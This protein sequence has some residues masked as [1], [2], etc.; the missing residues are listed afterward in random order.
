MTT[1][2]GHDVAQTCMSTVHIGFDQ[3]DADQRCMGTVMSGCRSS[4]VP[5]NVITVWI[6]NNAFR[7][8][9]HATVDQLRAAVAN[10]LHLAMPDLVLVYGKL[11]RH[12][13]ARLLEL[14]IQDNA[15]VV[16]QGG[17]G[18]G[19][20]PPCITKVA[21]QQAMGAVAVHATT[22][23]VEGM[24]DTLIPRVDI[25]TVGLN[26]NG[27]TCFLNTCLQV[28]G[29]LNAFQLAL[30]C[31]NSLR[32][33][34]S[35]E[36]HM[37]PVPKSFLVYCL[38]NYMVA[39]QLHANVIIQTS[40]DIMQRA[41]RKYWRDT[42][43]ADHGLG[44]TLELMDIIND[45]LFFNCPTFK[46]AV[47]MSLVVTTTKLC[48]ND[49]CALYLH[50]EHKTE[51]TDE[52]HIRLRG[53]HPG[54]T[55]ETAFDQREIARIW[56]QAEWPRCSNC[57]TPA[58]TSSQMQ[59]KCRHDV[60]PSV[61]MF[62][63][64][65]DSSVDHVA[66]HYRM[67]FIGPDLDVR[68]FGVH[69]QAKAYA[70][71]INPLH[72]IGIIRTLNGWKTC[73]DSIIS[74]TTVD[75]WELAK[76]RT[77]C[78]LL[79]SD[80][81][82]DLHAQAKFNL[83]YLE[84]NIQM[85]NETEADKRTRASMMAR[86][87]DEHNMRREAASRRQNRATHMPVHAKV[88]RGPAQVA[89]QAVHA[90]EKVKALES[91]AR[92]AQWQQKNYLYLLT[93]GRRLPCKQVQTFDNTKTLETFQAGI[94]D[95][96]LMSP[97][98]ELLV[99]DME[100]NARHARGRPVL[101]VQ[102]QTPLSSALPS[103]I[104]S[105]PE[106][107]DDAVITWGTNKSSF[108]K[109]KKY[110][111]GDEVFVAMA[112]SELAG[113]SIVHVAVAARVHLLGV[114]TETETSAQRQGQPRG[115]LSHVMKEFMR[116]RLC[117]NHVLTVNILWNGTIPWRDV[118]THAE[119]IYAREI[120]RDVASC[121][122]YNVRFVFYDTTPLTASLCLN[123]KLAY[124][125]NIGIVLALD[126]KPTPQLCA[127]VDAS[128]LRS[129]LDVS[130]RMIAA[131]SQVTVLKIAR[132]YMLNAVVAYFHEP[133]GCIMWCRS[134][135]CDPLPALSGEPPVKK[136][137]IHIQTQASSVVFSIH[138]I[139]ALVQLRTGSCAKS[140]TA[141]S[142][143]CEDLVLREMA[144]N[145]CGA[146]GVL[147]GQHGTV[148]ELQH[149]LGQVSVKASINK[150][151]KTYKK[152]TNN[153]SDNDISVAVL[154]GASDICG[155]GS[156]S[157]HV[158]PGV[159][160][161]HKADAIHPSQLPP[162][163]RLV[164]TPQALGIHITRKTKLRMTDLLRASS[165]L[166]EVVPYTAGSHR[167]KQ[168][169][170]KEKLEGSST[171]APAPSRFISVNADLI[172]NIPKADDLPT[173]QEYLQ[174]MS[175][176]QA[177]MHDIRQGLFAL[178]RVMYKL[179]RWM[180][181]F[182]CINIETEGSKSVIT[183][184]RTLVPALQQPADK[185]TP[186]YT[187]LAC[188]L[189]SDRE[190]DETDKAETTED[191]LASRRDFKKR[192]L[193]DT[194]PASDNPKVLKKV[195]KRST[196]VI[197]SNEP[198]SVMKTHNEQTPRVSSR[199]RRA[200]ARNQERA[201]D[202]ELSDEEKAQNKV[203]AGR[204]AGQKRKQQHEEDYVAF[205]VGA[206]NSDKK[207]RRN[208]RGCSTSA[209]KFV[210]PAGQGTLPQH[211]QKPSRPLP[212]D[213]Y[214]S[215]KKAKPTKFKG[216]H[217][218][219]VLVQSHEDLSRP[220]LH[221]NNQRS[222][223]VNIV[224]VMR[225]TAGATYFNMASHV[226]GGGPSPFSD[227]KH[228]STV[229]R[230][231]QVEAGEVH[232]QFANLLT[233][234]RAFISIQA[235][236]TPFAVVDDLTVVTGLRA[237]CLALREV[238]HDVVR[239]L[240]GNDQEL[241]QTCLRELQTAT[242]AAGQKSKLR[243]VPLAH[244][245]SK[246]RGCKFLPSMLMHLRAPPLPA[247][248]RVNMLVA[249][250]VQT[251]CAP[252]SDL[253]P[254]VLGRPQST[255]EVTARTRQ[256]LV[257]AP[258]CVYDGGG[259]MLQSK[260]TLQLS[261]E[262]AIGTL[263]INNDP[264]CAIKDTRP[265]RTRMM[266]RDPKRK[267]RFIPRLLELVPP[268]E[269]INTETLLGKPLHAPRHQEPTPELEGYTTVRR[270]KPWSAPA[271]TTHV[272]VVARLAR[273]VPFQRR[274]N[275][276]ELLSPYF[277]QAGCDAAGIWFSPLEH[278]RHTQ[279]LRA[280]HSAG[281]PAQ[282]AESTPTGLQRKTRRRCARRRREHQPDQVAG[283]CFAPKFRSTDP[284]HVANIE[285]ERR[286]LYDKLV[287]N[288]L[289]TKTDVREILDRA[290]IMSGPHANNIENQFDVVCDPLVQA[291]E[292]A[293]AT[294]AIMTGAS[295]VLFPL[296]SQ[297]MHDTTV[298]KHVNNQDRTVATGGH[299]ER[300]VHAMIED[301]D[302]SVAALRRM[303]TAMRACS[304]TGTC[305]GELCNAALLPVEWKC[306]IQ[307]FRDTMTRAAPGEPTNREVATM[308]LHLQ[309]GVL[310]NLSVDD[311]R[312]LILAEAVSQFAWQGEMSTNTGDAVNQGHQSHAIKLVPSLTI[313]ATRWSP[314][315]DFEGS[316][317]DVPTAMWQSL[318][319]CSDYILVRG[320]DATE[321]WV[322]R[323]TDKCNQKVSA[324]ALQD[325]LRWMVGQW[326]DQDTKPF[327]E[328]RGES[329]DSEEWR[330]VLNAAVSIQ[331][332]VSCGKGTNAL[333]DFH[334]NA[335]RSQLAQAGQDDATR[336]QLRKRM[337][338]IRNS[339]TQS[340]KKGHKTHKTQ[341]EVLSV[342]PPEAASQDSQ[343]FPILVSCPELVMEPTRLQAR[344]NMAGLFTSRDHT[345]LFNLE[346]TACTDKL[347][348]TVSHRPTSARTM[349]LSLTQDENVLIR[350]IFAHCG[351]SVHVLGLPST[352]GPS[353]MQA[354][355]VPLIAKG[356]SI[357]RMH[358]KDIQNICRKQYDLDSDEQLVPTH[359]NTGTADCEDWAREPTKALS[360]VI[361]GYVWMLLPNR[362]SKGESAASCNCKSNCTGRCSCFKDMRKCDPK[363]C[364]CVVG[365]CQNRIDVGLSEEQQRALTQATTVAKYKLAHSSIATSLNTIQQGDPWDKHATTRV[366]ADLLASAHSTDV[367]DLFDQFTRKLVFPQKWKERTPAAEYAESKKPDDT[368]L[369]R[370][371]LHVGAIMRANGIK[372]STARM[373][374]FSARILCASINSMGGPSLSILSVP[375]LDPP[376]ISGL[377]F[378]RLRAFSPAQVA[379]FRTQFVT[380]AKEHMD[381]AFQES[382]Q[383]E[384]KIE[385]QFNN[386][387]QNH[388]NNLDL[389]RCISRLFVHLGEKTAVTTVALA[390]FK[391]DDTFT[392][393]IWAPTDR[394]AL[395]TAL[396]LDAIKQRERGLCSAHQT[397]DKQGMLISNM[398]GG[399]L[400]S[401]QGQ[402]AGMRCRKVWQYT[403]V[404][405]RAIAEQGSRVQLPIPALDVTL[406]SAQ[407]IQWS[408]DDPSNAS[409]QV[410]HQRAP[411]VAVQFSSQL[412]RAMG[413]GELLHLKS[414]WRV[415]KQ[416]DALRQLGGLQ[417]AGGFMI[418]R[419]TGM[420]GNRKGAG[421]RIQ[422]PIQA[423]TRKSPSMSRVSVFTERS[424]S[425]QSLKPNRSRTRKVTER[426]SCD[427]SQCA[428]NDCSGICAA[429]SAC[430]DC[431]QPT[432]VR[433]LA[434]ALEGACVN[435]IS[436]FREQLRSTE[437]MM[438]VMYSQHR[439]HKHNEAFTFDPATMWPGAGHADL[440]RL[441]AHVTRQRGATK[442]S[443]DFCGGDE[444]RFV[445]VVDLG[446]LTYATITCVNTGE[447]FFVGRGC[448]RTIRNRFTVP[449]E[450]V[451]SAMD[452]CVNQ[453]QGVTQASKNLVYKRTCFVE[454]Q[455][456][457]G[458]C[459]VQL[460][461]RKDAERAFQTA[462]QTNRDRLAKT[463]SNFQKMIR[464]QYRLR[465]EQTKF[466]NNLI[467]VTSKLL[468]S[469]GEGGLILFPTNLL[470]D[471]NARTRGQTH[472]TSRTRGA[473]KMCKF[474]TLL[475]QLRHDCLLTGAFL[476]TTREDMSSKWCSI[477]GVFNGYLGQS[478]TFKCPNGNC[479]LHVSLHIH[480][481]DQ[482]DAIHRIRALTHFC[483]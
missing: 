26:N 319:D 122:V 339:K 56:E 441:K 429:F 435:D 241:Q 74:D 82:N 90:K 412:A 361:A 327:T 66:I 362:V 113:R 349:Q 317:D 84:P 227:E 69:Y 384:D 469:V 25:D 197:T 176:S 244:T 174:A 426:E 301:M 240:Q 359:T 16:L 177:Y 98:Q 475:R 294:R 247:S 18:L 280:D 467:K 44:D 402:D 296:L 392:S 183:W 193:A 179:E 7:C 334:I 212:D 195:K 274:S 376:K 448:G 394:G 51:I 181:S 79:E 178:T 443:Y 331:A 42:F 139:A 190:P 160:N 182:S 452:H 70:V 365:K 387:Q 250:S 75:D 406:V 455:A 130:V 404:Q 85:K 350:G 81:G 78:I 187:Y 48:L 239:T 481:L 252:C 293:S 462:I 275:L 9:V 115:G 12:G 68:K 449:L 169:G 62:T 123:K 100:T 284:G 83:E 272:N 135:A 17:R 286:Q 372:N 357:L 458:N 134:T 262:L 141:G 204:S 256:R 199:I 444:K 219:L 295:N 427:H 166:T 271:P 399:Q 43:A 470:D 326:W 15:T 148:E 255:V 432:T 125:Y 229:L 235:R 121:T 232:Q 99:I 352:T 453:T 172:V 158:W 108:E 203:P 224:P 129:D 143:A 249:E 140:E 151:P 483:R 302:K 80:S 341:A 136:T 358:T 390:L 245:D 55:L 393:F 35:S 318:L 63:T 106:L 37:L 277:G 340:N 478:R 27:N 205:E 311:T 127:N 356:I 267:T 49:S 336:V 436:V 461:E 315:H 19:G 375:L 264:A 86:R 180:Q 52:S 456:V 330:T 124:L 446:V 325:A 471:C 419:G 388:P 466:I 391:H 213:T 28:L 36:V 413:T 473:I 4:Q 447:V 424:R 355:N 451:Q 409:V 437:R 263:Q 414:T 192:C 120:S 209:S 246:S 454:A 368:N 1:R 439:H 156:F 215:S 236:N 159:A 276:F 191:C 2:H 328:S 468:S 314:Q 47:T 434:P 242:R 324:L 231:Q 243:I 222:R 201:D 157:G 41:L 363:I 53:G 132:F 46:L 72:H 300:P 259:D 367:V 3:S 410:S 105:I 420:A 425:D 369:D 378:E 396:Q 345:E 386:W 398:A 254:A 379:A 292:T 198:T 202:I 59:Y 423:N 133:S 89:A 118:L 60:V 150:M 297:C 261:P 374:I 144:A 142:T 137:S 482:T 395:L 380:T 210:Q 353:D 310:R 109:G 163:V 373:D 77:H 445:L 206:P 131:A 479:L 107:Q 337:P 477:C 5:P 371:E 119:K 149:R 370:D 291:Q 266:E 22:D 290:V 408:R 346:N 65:K 313:T 97:E 480:A 422:L 40:I 21:S 234:S 186:G 306:V 316:H 211:V 463:D 117:W 103:P 248:S 57:N 162:T 260:V 230:D 96:G 253:L 474:G 464:E 20:M 298:S 299:E 58:K 220:E 289:T 24:Q 303:N 366:D 338:R 382:K 233:S 8:C 104:K 184:L 168:A 196:R 30:L 13:K 304:T 268:E 194:G 110:Y 269:T 282:T 332:Q 308:R 6:G 405:P 217:G 34:Y 417:L 67:E 351:P 465:D 165:H 200:P 154:P 411:A 93:L 305:A 415:A 270:K 257:L 407:G 73:N 38:T 14:G 307:T 153:L 343:I 87:R 342:A 61:L 45:V 278:L 218:F 167:T 442:P 164:D 397:R 348:I 101:K 170:P 265:V 71:N 323:I 128:D 226:Y 23:S 329:R 94:F 433:A 216:I 29:T 428:G 418:W 403:S 238:K 377:V 11:L 88:D 450:K 287:V 214:G 225:M 145:L 438:Q 472:Q 112:S 383:D 401:T 64:G 389:L 92:V 208:P 161:W 185:H 281:H 228:Q 320:Q 95:A 258:A 344:I 188:M 283:E 400:V 76:S 223:D 251:Q 91:E 10:R 360:R 354:R 421:L 431:Q 476:E 457:E 152:M 364:G 111:S 416:P 50:P 116:Q 237:N 288:Q 322:V 54:D 31:D 114:L 381:A 207:K 333:L 430:L 175:Q 147:I 279:R 102:N 321:L 440:Q 189:L 312:Q 347:T 459:S 146:Q 39:R 385:E 285:Q 273:R 33:A 309:L 173:H 126:T 138:L 171:N 32:Q 460:R 155:S 221:S 335:L